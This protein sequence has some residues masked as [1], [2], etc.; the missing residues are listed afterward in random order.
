M[1]IDIRTLFVVHALVSVALAALM[2]LFWRA[3]RTL[4]GLAQ[5]TLGTGL[6]GASILGV[7]LRGVLPDF[8]SIV[9]ANGLSAASLAAFWNGVRLFDGRRAHWFVPIAVALATAA[10]L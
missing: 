4:P 9:I 6:L 5:W 7:A 1:H 10:F 3:H 8:V 2:I